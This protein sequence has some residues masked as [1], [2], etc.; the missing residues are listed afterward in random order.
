MIE[1][2]LRSDDEI[3]LLELFM[4]LWRGKWL[5]STFVTICFVIALGYTQL[6][7][8]E[9]SIKAPYSVHYEFDKGMVE[10][11]LFSSLGS[12]WVKDSNVELGEYVTFKTASRNPLDIEVYEQIFDT[13]GKSLNE[14]I[15]AQHKLDFEIIQEFDEPLLNTNS[16]AEKLLEARRIIFQIENAGT[17]AVSFK[18]SNLYLVRPKTK[19]ILALSIILGGFLGAATVLARNA[20]K[21]RKPIGT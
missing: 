5:I 3:D 20:V 15:L 4:A 12:D 9:Y 17:L 6:S 21:S 1:N 11:I 18:N 14:V 7:P 13:I 19:L 10:R 8:R 2:K 16:S